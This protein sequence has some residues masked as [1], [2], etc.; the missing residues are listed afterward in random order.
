MTSY[1]KYKQ[2]LDNNFNP[3]KH[4][5]NKNTGEF[6]AKNGEIYNVEEG[7]NF[8]T[9]YIN[10]WYKGQKIGGAD[11]KIDKGLVLGR[12]FE[13]DKDHQ[14]VGLGKEIVHRLEKLGKLKFGTNNPSFWTHMGY[15]K[16]SDN[17]WTKDD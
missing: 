10:M 9:N 8:G 5:R 13:I 4:P 7:A 1:L 14:G 2:T 15:S 6:V 16:K 3:S 11:F 12:S 17:Y